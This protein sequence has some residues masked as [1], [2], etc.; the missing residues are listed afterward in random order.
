MLSAGP[1]PTRNLAEPL[2]DAAST[3]SHNFAKELVDLLRAAG[4]GGGQRSTIQ[5]KPDVT[6]PK[7]ADND[8]DIDSFFEELEDVCGLAN[9]AKGMSDLERLRCLGNCLQGN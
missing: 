5:I 7:L 2:D 9:D 4:G 1:S 3:A 6:W 8:Q